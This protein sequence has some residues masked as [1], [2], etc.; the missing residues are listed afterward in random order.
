[1]FALKVESLILRT[2]FPDESCGSRVG[3]RTALTWG[4]SFRVFPFRYP[5]T[6]A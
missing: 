1:M 3:A 6:N 4:A 2:M 5:V